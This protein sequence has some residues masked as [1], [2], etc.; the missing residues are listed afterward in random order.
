M[1]ET[2]GEE[3]AGGCGVLGRSDDGWVIHL[4]G[5]LSSSCESF[6]SKKKDVNLC[7]PLLDRLIG[8][9]T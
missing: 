4:F 5:V 6:C 2:V 9:V 1:E 7:S 3:A 8:Y